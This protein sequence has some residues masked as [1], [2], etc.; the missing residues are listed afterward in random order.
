M[1]TKKQKLKVL[2][3]SGFNNQYKKF[4]EKLSDEY[5][6][7]FITISEVEKK[8]KEGLLRPS[9]DLLLFT[10]GADVNPELYD[11]PKGS[12]TS[13][14]KDRDLE[15]KSIFNVY[16]HVP[17]LG[18]CRGSQLL[19]VLNGGKL[20]Q[21]VT[22]HTKDHNIHLKPINKRKPL[23]IRRSVYVKPLQFLTLKMTSTHHQMMFPYNLKKEDYS[24]IGWSQ[25]YLSKEYLNGNDENIKLPE[26]FLEPEIVF[27]KRSNSLC[28]QGHPEFDSCSPITKRIILDIIKKKLLEKKEHFDF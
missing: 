14:N 24:I 4:I 22:G 17:K 13:I 11:E 9:I 12:Y 1:I 7:T 15:E 2:V 5:D 18:I 3:D 20:I 6:I 21:N 19:T 25:K 10:G 28:I 23:E 27:Y 8:F 16:Y 26:K